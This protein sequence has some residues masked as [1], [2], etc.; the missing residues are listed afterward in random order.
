MSTSS[1]PS[2]IKIHLAVLE[3]KSKMWKVYGRTT[4]TTTTTDGRTD[5]GRCAMTIAHSSLRLRWAKNSNSLR[6]F[7]WSPIFNIQGN[8]IV[9]S[10]ND[11]TLYTWY[12]WFSAFWR[13]FKHEIHNINMKPYYCKNYSRNTKNLQL[14]FSFYTLQSTYKVETWLPNLPECVRSLSLSLSN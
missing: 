11:D 3:K 13:M 10:Y 4:T 9:T 2:F 6:Y 5:D 12:S 14:S 8:G 7:F 1:L